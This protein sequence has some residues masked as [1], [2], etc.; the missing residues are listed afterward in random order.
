M[1]CQALI[2]NTVK[3]WLQAR[4][5]ARVTADPASSILVQSYTAPRAHASASVCVLHHN[6]THLSRIGTG[7]VRQSI[8]VELNCTHRTPKSPREAGKSGCACERCYSLAAPSRITFL[9]CASA[10]AG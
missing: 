6:G 3:T 7:A 9:T 1:R 8:Q 5:R 10:E 2:V 4:I